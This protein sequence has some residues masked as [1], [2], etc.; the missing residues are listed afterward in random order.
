M[1]KENAP[2]KMRKLKDFSDT[3]GKRF[4]VLLVCGILLG[5]VIW[6]LVTRFE[7]RR[8]FVYTR[9]RMGSD[10]AAHPGWLFL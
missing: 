4:K 5:P 10:D 9:G 3:S 7:N 6:F 1:E 2:I 8:C